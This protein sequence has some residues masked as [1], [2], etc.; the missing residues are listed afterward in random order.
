MLKKIN[1]IISPKL[2]KLLDEMGHTEELVIC[3]GNM[4][5][6][7]LNKR[8]VRLDGHNVPEI[9]KAILEIFPLDDKVEKPAAIVNWDGP[10][11]PIWDEYK[12]IILNSEEGNKFKAG[13]E[14]LSNDDFFER[15]RHASVLIATTEK[16][17]AGNILLRKGLM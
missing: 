16:T 9:L 10:R 6:K 3:D 15:S 14:M 8:I 2:L 5:V 1:P 13:F 4:P 11:Q 7:T 17:L 12:E